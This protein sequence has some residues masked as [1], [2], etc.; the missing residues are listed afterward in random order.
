MARDISSGNRINLSSAGKLDG[1]SPSVG[2]IAAWVNLD[3]IAPAAHWV[4]TTPDWGVGFN[5][6][7]LRFTKFGVIDLPST[8]GFTTGSW[9]FAAV[10]ADAANIHFLKMATDGT[11][12][13]GDVA[14][15]NALAAGGTTGMIG[16]FTGGGGTEPLDGR[17]AHLAVWMGSFLT[18]NELVAYARGTAP[19]TPTLWMPLYGHVTPETDVSASP[20]STTHTGTPGAVDHAPVGRPRR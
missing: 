13:T 8:V 12:T 19:R 20:V 14:N 2:T 6:G 18:D 7:N 10:V 16:A 5:F 3:S 15:A 17:V 11:R 9:Q 4:L 1:A